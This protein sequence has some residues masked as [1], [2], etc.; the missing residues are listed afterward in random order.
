[1][2]P[3]ALGLL[4][5]TVL[6]APAD[7]P[8]QLSKGDGYAVHALGGSVGAWAVFGPQPV[9]ALHL[10]HTS[11]PSGKLTVLLRTGTTVGFPVPMGLNRVPHSQTRVVGVAAD[12]ERLYVL[13]WTAKWVV[14]DH[15]HGAYKPPESDDYAVQVYWLKDGTE[16]G[17]FAVGGAKRP[18]VLPRESVEVGPLVVEKEGGVSVYGETFRFK[19]KERVK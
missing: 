9:T 8:V 11:F 17:T 2:T 3:L 18:K 14:E 5:T 16:V 1:M 12:S 6:S 13:V 10:L 4:A 15:G 7:E 19:G